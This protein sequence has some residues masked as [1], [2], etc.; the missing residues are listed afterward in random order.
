MHV[1]LVSTRYVLGK[2][3]YLEFKNDINRHLLRETKGDNKQKTEGKMEI[4]PN[5]KSMLDENIVSDHII[6]KFED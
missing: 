4:K 1:N 6:K 5:R 3:L 2:D